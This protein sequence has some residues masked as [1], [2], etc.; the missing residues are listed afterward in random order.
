M[1]GGSVA[2]IPGREGSPV[3][4]CVFLSPDPSRACLFVF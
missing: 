4:A 1:G 3:D 2:Q